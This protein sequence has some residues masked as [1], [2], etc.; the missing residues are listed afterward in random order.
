MP[1]PEF[2]PLEK[3]LKAFL[4]KRAH[5]AVVVDEYGGAVGIVTLDDVLGELVGEI[6]DEF[7]QEQAREFVRLSDEEFVVQGQLNLYE[8]QELAGLELETADVS[9]IG[10]YV[11]QLL[12]HLPR[13]GEQVHIEGYLV[14]ITQTDGR[15]ILQLHFKRDQPA[16]KGKAEDELKESRR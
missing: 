11:V 8:L 2:M 15:R 6:K 7:D 3:L 4:A 16:P 9:T 1:V 10:G 13:Q 14:T 5:L 12:G